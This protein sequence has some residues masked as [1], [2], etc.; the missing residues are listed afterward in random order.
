SNNFVLTMS[1]LNDI[2]DEP[3]SAFSSKTI[4]SND[5][6]DKPTSAFSSKMTKLTPKRQEQLENGICLAFVCAGV[7][8]NVATNKIFRAWIQ[9]LKPG[10]K[11]PSSKTLAG[12]I[13]NKQTIRV[14]SKI[15]NK[16]QTKNCITLDQSIWNFLLLTPDQKEHL[17][18]LRNYLATSYIAEFLVQEIEM[19]ITQIGLKKICAVVTDGGAN[20]VATR[21][22]ITQK[23]P[24]IMNVSCIAHRLNLICK[25]IMKESFAK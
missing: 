12:R 2:D 10:F 19:I 8:F 3:T 15:E 16:L 5:I 22:L 20:V 18:A 17:Y 4:S 24:Q 23:F 13:F 14:E 11:I 21:R 7:S 1:L 6:D 9:D 25:D